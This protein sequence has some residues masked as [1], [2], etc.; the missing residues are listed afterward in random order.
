MYR[1]GIAW[2]IMVGVCLRGGDGLLFRVPMDMAAHSVLRS[3]T[4]STTSPFE[5]GKTA[6]SVPREEA[7]GTVGTASGTKRTA[8][9]TESTVTIS[10]IT[11]IKEEIRE[12]PVNMKR[13]SLPL[14]G[15]LR[16]GA[17]VRNTPNARRRTGERDGKATVR[18]GS[19]E[20]RGA[21][22]EADLAMLAAVQAQLERQRSTGEARQG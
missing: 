10:S 14:Q 16:T 19:E 17:H 21:D 12:I 18:E 1:K 2:L 3:G 5:V 20:G 15:T 22:F 8:S 11:S 4:Q 6:H 7:I 13:E 9:G